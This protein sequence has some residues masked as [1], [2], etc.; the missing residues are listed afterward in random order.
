MVNCNICIGEGADIEE[1]QRLLDLYKY[2]MLYTPSEE[3]I[4]SI[5]RL[6]QI[7]CETP[8]CLVSLLD[9]EKQW[10]KSRQGLDVSETDRD[11]SFC[12]YAIKQNTIFEV[13]DA[14]KDP[15]FANTPLV[16]GFPYIRHYAGMPLKSSNGHNIGTLCVIDSK[17]GALSDAQRIALETLAKQVILQ[18]EMKK[19]LKELK[20]ANEKSMKLSLV[21]DEF[22]SNMSHE[23]RT[24]L[25]AIFGFTEILQ[26]SIK[27][28]KQ[29]EYLDIIKSSVEILISII[30]DILDFSKIELGKL[31]IEKKPF[32]LKKA[33]KEIFELLK[34]KA[35]EKNLQFKF[36]I[37]S[38]I[39]RVIVGDK[40]RLNQILVN[41][42]GNAIKFTSKGK[43]EIIVRRIKRRE[44]EKKNLI[45]ENQVKDKNFNKVN[46]FDDLSKE[47]KNFDNEIKNNLNEEMVRNVKLI[48][49][50]INNNEGISNVAELEII[51]KDTGIGIKDDK[52]DK[53]FERFE[54]AS[55]EI[56]RNYGGSGLGLSISKNLVELQ[57]GKIKVRSELGKGSEFIINI[58]YEYLRNLDSSH[59]QETVYKPEQLSPNL[60]INQSINFTQ[61][62]ESII[63][64]TNK[65]EEIKYKENISE[66]S[67][68]FIYKNKKEKNNFNDNNLTSELYIKQQ[69]KINLNHRENEGYLENKEQLKEISLIDED[70]EDTINILLCEDN[71]FNIKLIEKILFDSP[72]KNNI[73]LDIAQNGKI[74]GEMVKN[75]P[76]KYD[77]IL[78]DLQMPEKNGLETSVYIRNE[79]KLNIPI[80]AMTANLCS[81]ERK[82]CFETGINEYFTKPFSKKEFFECFNILL[83]KK[84]YRIKE[85]N[86]LKNK[87]C[88]GSYS[89]K[90]R[91]IND[92]KECFIG[93]GNKQ[94]SLTTSQQNNNPNTNNHVKQSSKTES[95]G[96]R[97]ITNKN[98]IN[99]YLLFENLLNS[100]KS[101]IDNSKLEVTK[102]SKE[103]D[104]LIYYNMN[105][106]KST[107]N[108]KINNYKYDFS[109]K[110]LNI[111][112]P[113]NHKISLSSRNN[114][115]KRDEVKY[116]LLEN[117]DINYEKNFKNKNLISISKS[118]YVNNTSLN[119]NLKNSEN[120]DNKIMNNGNNKN[121]SLRKEKIQSIKNIDIFQIPNSSNNINGINK[122]FK[123]SM[124][125]S[126]ISSH[127][128]DLNQ[129]I[130]KKEKHQSKTNFDKNPKTLPKKLEKFYTQ[131]NLS[132]N[133]DKKQKNLENLEIKKS[134][135]L[136]HYYQDR[137]SKNIEEIHKIKSAVRKS[138]IL[139]FPQNQNLEDELK[140]SFIDNIVNKKINLIKEN[141]EI[142]TFNPNLAKMNIKKKIEENFP[143]KNNIN[144]TQICNTNISLK[145]RLMSSNKKNKLIKRDIIPKNIIENPAKC[146]NSNPIN[147]MNL[148]FRNLKSNQIEK[149]NSHYN[150]NNIFNFNFRKNFKYFNNIGEDFIYNL[151][152][153]KINLETFKEF[154]GD[155]S[156]TEKEI[157]ES[158]LKEFPELVNEFENAVN[159]MDFEQINKLCHKLKSPISIFG[160]NIVK[161]KIINIEDFTKLVIKNGESLKQNFK[162]FKIA[163]DKIYTELKILV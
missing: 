79:L 117:N 94:K 45:Q 1:E 128:K 135:F 148:D 140:I 17:P 6:T 152:K 25:N 151:E 124:I 37:S 23:L 16:T 115:K 114:I 149:F 95:F 77:L 32:D 156:E 19:V 68:D 42:I 47:N 53:I 161:E 133:I 51:V 81:I 24:P 4:D 84:I 158:F 14:S 85:L 7:I 106:I 10:F 88:I 48:A 78:M 66:N 71:N 60:T 40:V 125:N 82:R 110:F 5:T 119:K 155:E 59:M 116:Y 103:D 97:D 102:K 64:E 54:Q 93:N 91:I 107:Q 27:N 38:K 122:S 67:K 30:N 13:N 22:L 132:N 36:Y 69:N 80:V 150:I 90:T 41:L 3:T 62:E 39:P 57:G 61:F 120:K 157:I 111:S 137:S 146:F 18:F 142:N 9:R 153:E 28:D 2:E 123:N 101:K 118:D 44:N 131:E 162:N 21:K 130:L 141:K 31:V 49:N 154:T 20:I 104:N 92:I 160:L 55:S 35:N 65:M 138:N 8:I 147:G 56:T 134:N 99:N 76:L 83:K 11:I 109:H 89:P 136:I 129:N 163:M 75:N 143:Y 98:T 87:S 139:N 86:K 144:N 33:L 145:N 50:D 96:K 112:E 12:K 26:N 73:S 159:K 63:Y 15:R 126:K 29:K 100:Q 108:F 43:I 52:L 113:I 34:Q 105:S 46:L 70:N 121:Y 74:G 72:F 58:A 127:L